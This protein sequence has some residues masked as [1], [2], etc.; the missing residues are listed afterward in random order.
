MNTLIEVLAKLNWF[1]SVDELMRWLSGVKSWKFAVSR[2]CGWSGQQIEEMLAKYG[3]KVWGRGFT[4]DTL[5]FRV[6]YQQANW[7]EYLLWQH[8][9]T[10]HSSPFNPQNRQYGEQRSFNPHNS[11]H[12]KEPDWLDSLVSFFLQ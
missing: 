4:R 9:I 2:N 6:K 8:R 10:V 3:V 5:T 7:A 1:E 11:P 12:Q